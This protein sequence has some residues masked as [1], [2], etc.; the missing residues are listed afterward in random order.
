MQAEDQ[1][2]PGKPSDAGRFLLQNIAHRRRVYTGS[3]NATSSRL[4]ANREHE[5]H[6]HLKKQ[7]EVD[8]LPAITPSE[9]SS[10]PSVEITDE[11]SS[12]FSIPGLKLSEEVAV[13]QK[14]SNHS[15]DQGAT[16]NDSASADVIKD[17][18]ELRF[19]ED[20]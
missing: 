10:L 13:N 15:E 20:D 5:F 9:R 2:I 17:L 12:D 3:A 19:A 16:V 18:G 7:I 4:H 1:P 11:K 14:Q 6:P 8:Q